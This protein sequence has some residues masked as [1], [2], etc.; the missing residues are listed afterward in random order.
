M[1]VKI[2]TD[3]VSDLPK[4]LKEA[5]DIEVLPLMVNF[6]DASYR[7]GIDLTPEM[8]F[9]KLKTSSTLPTTS[10]VNVGQ[11]VEAYERVLAEGNEA[12]VITLSSKL[13]GTYSAA[14]TALAEVGTDQISVI[15]SKAVSFGLGLLVI[16]TAE[17]VQ[18]GLGRIEIAE[19]CLDLSNRLEMVLFVDTLT[20]LQKGGRLSASEAVIGNLLKI[21]PVLTMKDGALASLD[22]VRGRKKSLKWFENYIQDRQADMEDATV[23]FYHAED[24]EF[25]EAL[26]DVA[27]S[28]SRPGKILRSTVGSVVGTHSGPGCVAYSY[29][30]KS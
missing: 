2:I 26:I 21:K 11:F 24:P 23:A 1:A 8:F 6:E 28:V 9:E 14:V 12:V 30:R 13:S 22:K 3:S 15:D 17:L 29:F 18:E 5:Y 19:K 20:Y 4:E 16:K 27:L 10:Q 25:M 7:D